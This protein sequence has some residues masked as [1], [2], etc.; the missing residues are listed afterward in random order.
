M[1]KLE[2]LKDD[3]NTLKEKNGTSEAQDMHRT[4][5]LHQFCRDIESLVQSGGYNPQEAYQF[6]K[7]KYKG[8]L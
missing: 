8:R 1:I 7:I 3:C 2:Q 4:N 5:E 6:I